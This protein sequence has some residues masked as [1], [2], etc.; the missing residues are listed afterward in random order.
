MRLKKLRRFFL[1]FLIALFGVLVFLFVTINLPFSRPFVTRQVN[2]VL[3]QSNVPIQINTIRKILPGSVNL[4][5][6]VITDLCGDTIIYAGKVLADIS[7]LPLL[8]SKVMVRDVEVDQAV[9]EIIRDNNTQEYIPW[10][11]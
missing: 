9:V 4:Q 8:R 7:L 5:G 11:T 6:V 10:G 2:Q 3:S 1:I